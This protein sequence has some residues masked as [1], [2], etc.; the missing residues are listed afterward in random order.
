MKI[1]MVCLGNICRSPLAEGIARKKLEHHGLDWEIDSAGTGDW[2]IGHAP[3]P[4]S[5]STA[6]A[7]SID[8]SGLRARQIAL[9]DLEEFDLIVTM[10]RDNHQHVRAMANGENRHK[11]TMMLDYL[12]PGEGRPVP[13][14]YFGGSEGFE[15]VYDLLDAACDAM[16]L[17]LQNR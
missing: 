7:R 3:D 8:I 2:H 9:Q 12:Y 1:L 14:P 4:R 6:A 15:K 11:I 13:D 5:I 10:D 16:I 17:E